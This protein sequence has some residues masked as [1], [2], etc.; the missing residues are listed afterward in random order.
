MGRRARTKAQLLEELAE[1]R[2]RLAALEARAARGAGGAGRGEDASEPPAA[3]LGEREQA[4]RRSGA[5]FRSLI[6]NAQD[7]ITVLDR[8][9]VIRYES[10]SVERALGYRPDELVGRDVFALVHP[11]DVARVSRVFTHGVAARR[12]ATTVEV[13]FRHKDG[14]WRHFECAGR[15]LLADPD[16]GGVVVNSRDVT[17]RVRL[18]QEILRVA[19]AQRQE[20]GW[21][22]HDGLGQHLAG[23]AHLSGALARRLA[24]AAPAESAEAQKLS[25]L[26]GRAVELARSLARGLCPSHIAEGDLAKGLEELAATVSELHR[27]DCRFECRGLARLSDRPAAVHL[28]RIAQ[29]AVA[30]A[31]RHGRPER[32]RIALAVERGRLA[33][34]VANDGVPFPDHAERKEGLGLRIMQLRADAIGA[35]L[36]VRR[37]VPTG[38]VVACCCPIGAASKPGSKDREP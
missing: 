28:C 21:E 17:E 35:S 1:L 10:P 12:P 3:E 38:T 27:V 33:L 30:N 22:M 24:D 31:L 5:Y 20:I 34:T 4:L 8:E 19:E 15:N 9:G 25:A 7:V 16:V 18:E 26:A 37:G 6:E 11:A 14:S 23:I 36:D 2:E 29:E 13:R 32:I